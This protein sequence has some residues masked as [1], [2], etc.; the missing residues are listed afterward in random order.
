MN[1][2]RFDSPIYLLIGLIVV[3]GIYFYWKRDIS[4]QRK[5]ESYNRA[6]HLCLIGLILIGLAEPQILINN[7][8]RCVI[9]LLDVSNSIKEDAM[10]EARDY[11]RSKIKEK[12][13]GDR[14]GVIQFGKEADL[15]IP[16]IDLPE[17]TLLTALSHST[18]PDVGLDYTDIEGA[19]RIALKVFPDILEKKIVLVTDGNENA[20]HISRLYDELRDSKIT[21][22]ILSIGGIDHKEI[23]IESIHV[24]EK[25]R[26]G[27]PFSVEVIIG[28][29]IATSADIEIMT[30][31]KL[32]IE[33]TIDILPGDHQVHRFPIVLKERGF[34]SI[35]A[36]IYSKQDTFLANNRM[37]TL[38]YTLGHPR[39]L[40]VTDP[41][42]RGSLGNHYLQG[43]LIKNSIDVETSSWDQLPLSP[44]GYD[45]YDVII[46]NNMPTGAI[47]RQQM[48][49]ISSAVHDLGIGLIMIGGRESIRDGGYTR[50]PIET[51]LPVRLMPHK[52]DKQ[53]S[54]DLVLVMDKSGSMSR[55]E[56]DS[57]IRLA[58]DTTQSIIEILGK[59]DRIGLIAFDNKPHIIADLDSI[60]KRDEVIRKIHELTP[61]GSTDF[62]PALVHAHQWLKTSEASYKHILL[63]SDGRTEDR[64]LTGLVRKMAEDGITI[65]VIGIGRDS[66]TT[67]LKKIAHIG[68]GRFF[69]IAD[70]GFHR[71]RDILMMD[72]IMTANT[73]S[74]EETFVPHLKDPDPILNGIPLHL[75][76]MHGYM[77]TSP[78]EGAVIPIVS[79][80]GDPIVGLWRYGLGKSAILT[81]DD[82]SSW[83]RDWIIW[84]GYGRLWLQLVRRIMRPGMDR[85]EDLLFHIHADRAEIQYK[86]LDEKELPLKTIARI[87]YP[88]GEMYDLRLLQSSPGIYTGRLDNLTEGRYIILIMRERDGNAIEVERGSFV[89]NGAMEFLRLNKNMGLIKEIASNTGGNILSKDD[90]IF[91][92]DSDGIKQYIPIGQYIFI[93]AIALFLID[94][95]IYKLEVRELRS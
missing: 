50:T 13:N 27:N 7:W 90:P 31:Q 55:G 82:G 91:K 39:V 93:L 65:S 54:M 83:S 33:S 43:I 1:I 32:L 12:G 45:G 49:A 21:V 6:I 37:E 64:A 53:S 75:P 14:I 78:K 47:I 11:I 92:K 52:G 22:D 79:H 20:G 5:E 95:G 42:S 2:I 62:Y 66:N 86:V 35:S 30:D 71:L 88:D 85:D 70:N 60:K 80:R 63:L 51:T 38:S 24:P 48:E 34:H 44:E 72:T 3:T 77:V 18:M 8:G 40:F 29:N 68:K 73:L 67:L 81:G 36:K 23:I 74:V 16:P 89:I 76:S 9:F 10:S 17:Q 56:R 61:G 28:S 59:D 94:I 46:L 4:Q 69:R 58:I 26:V 57:K 87:F 84:D 25:V 15:I 19:I 41:S